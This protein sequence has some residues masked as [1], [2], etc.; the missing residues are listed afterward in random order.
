MVAVLSPDV[1]SQIRMTIDEYLIADLPEGIRYELVEGMVQMSPTPGYDHDTVIAKL[2]NLFV[3]YADAHPEIVGHISQ[4]AGVAVVKRETVREPD[5][6]IYGPGD[7]AGAA[8]KTWKGV[9]PALVVEVVSPGQIQRDYEEK[10][11]DYWD[12]GVQEY[13]IVDAQRGGIT[14]LVRRADAWH[15]SFFGSSET[16]RPERF[17]EL[18][19]EVAAVLTNG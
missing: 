1:L 17:P 10:R 8:E 16:Y 19:V 18:A 11:R 15:E 7:I 12:A 3:R 4:R 5:F 13:W 14:T 6:A 2:N 9:R